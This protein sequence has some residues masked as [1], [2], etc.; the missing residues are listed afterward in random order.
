MLI[1][2]MWIDLRGENLPPMECDYRQEI[3]DYPVWVLEV[4]NAIVGGLDHGISNF[5]SCN[6]RQHCY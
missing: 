4:E 1:H 3:I 5:E 2:L 6:Y